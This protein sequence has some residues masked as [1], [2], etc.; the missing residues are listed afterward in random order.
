VRAQ[1]ESSS[2]GRRSL[3]KVQREAQTHQSLAVYQIFEKYNS[4]ARNA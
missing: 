2:S 3:T 1:N 4:I